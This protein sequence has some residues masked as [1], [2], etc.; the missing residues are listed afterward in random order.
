MNSIDWN[1]K[2]A[3][4]SDVNIVDYGVKQNTGMCSPTAATISAAFSVPMWNLK[5]GV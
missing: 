4:I 2:D 1:E 5:S 3:P